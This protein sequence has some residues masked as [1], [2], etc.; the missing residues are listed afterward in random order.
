MLKT[1]VINIYAKQL[2]IHFFKCELVLGLNTSDQCVYV[3]LHQTRLTFIVCRDAEQEMM[4]VLW[5]LQTT[6]RRT[7]SPPTWPPQLSR[8]CLTLV[9]RLEEFRKRFP[10]LQLE[11]ELF[12]QAGRSVMAGLA[13]PTGQ[14]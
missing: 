9:D 4:I 7:P 13:R 5:R 1:N 12:V 6:F 14:S 11:D 10:T 3:V 2:A 8:R